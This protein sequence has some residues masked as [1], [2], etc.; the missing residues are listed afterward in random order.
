MISK[1]LLS[2]LLSLIMLVG[3]IPVSVFADEV[4]AALFDELLEEVAENPEAEEAPVETEEFEEN[5]TET[6]PALDY[7]DSRGHEIIT[8]VLP[9]STYPE[10]EHSGR[11]TGETVYEFSYP[12][13]NKLVVKFDESS[14]LGY[15]EKLTVYD[16]FDTKHRTYSY[17]D[18]NISNGSFTIYGE[19]FKLVLLS[20]YYDY[21]YGF[22]IA[23]IEVTYPE[24]VGTKAGEALPATCTEKGHKAGFIC[25]LCGED[26]PG[27]IIPA[28]GHSYAEKVVKPTADDFGYTLF[29]CTVCGD[30][31]AGSYRG[32]NSYKQG[33]I[34]ET[35]SWVI[36]GDTLYILGEGEMPNDKDR[37]D[38]SDWCG[39]VKSI[40]ITEGVTLIGRRAFETAWDA[41]SVSIPSTVTYIGDAAFSNLKKLQSADLP[42]GLTYIGQ[43]AF[44]HCDLRK[45]II[46]DSVTYLGGSAFSNNPNLAEVK[47][48][49]GITEL[50]NYAF[51]S[52]N[53]LESVYIPAKV[54]KIG[55]SAF[56]R[57]PKLWDVMFAVV[58]ES[59]EYDALRIDPYAFAYCDIKEIHL[60][61]NIGQIAGHAF[62]GNVNLKGVYVDTYDSSNGYDSTK[63]KTDDRGCVYE[64]IRNYDTGEYYQSVLAVI[65]GA[66]SGS[67]VVPDSVDRVDAAIQDMPNLNSFT[68]GAGCG[69]IAYTSSFSNCPNLHTVQTNAPQTGERYWYNGKYGEFLY[70]DDGGKTAEV[71]FLPCNATEYTLPANV[72]VNRS[73]AG[74][75]GNAPLKNVYVESGNTEFESIDGVLYKGDTLYYYP[76]AKTAKRYTVPKGIR[77]FETDAL[78]NPN[79][80]ELYFKGDFCNVE[81]D[82]L[83]LKSITV[84]YP[85]DNKTWE[86]EQL[87]EIVRSYKNAYG[88][89][90]IFKPYYTDKKP[91]APAI[92]ATVV[93]STGKPKITWNKVDGAA[94][95]EVWRATT[96]TGTGTK[97]STVTGTTLTNKNAVAGKSYYYYVKAISAGGKVSANSNR[98]YITCDYAAP[99]IKVSGVTSAGNPKIT[100]AKVEGA[101]SYKIYRATSK[102]GV[103][104][105]VKT[106]TGTSYT[107]TSGKVGKRY[108]YKV[109]AFGSNSR[110]TS[111]YSNVVSSTKLKRPIITLRSVVATGKTKVSWKAITGAE[112]YNVYRATKENGS[113]TLM[114]NVT[115]LDWIDESA[116]PGRQ[117]FYKI[118]AINESNNSGSAYSEV[119]SR[120]TDLEMPVVDIMLSSGKPKLSWKTVIGAKQ[121]KIYRA[122]SKT[123]KY[124]LVKTTTKNSWKDTTAKSGKT[125]YY[126][127]IAAHKNSNANS[128]Y[129]TVVSIKSVSN[130]KIN[131][132]SA[133]LT[134]GETLKLSIT[135]TT[136]KTTW[137]SS[138]QFVATVNSKGKVT[139]KNIGNVTIYAKVDGVTLKCEI[140]VVASQSD[141]LKMMAAMG[142]NH[143]RES[144]K[145]PSTLHIRRITYNTNKINGYGDHIYRMVIECY[146]QNSLGGY[147][148]FYT[149]VIRTEEQTD[150]RE[151]AYYSGYGEFTASSF[152]SSPGLETNVYSNSVAVDAYKAIYNTNIDIPYD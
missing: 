84:W 106:Q 92:K 24:H 66:I 4:D 15:A 130:A 53:A 149:V 83:G 16:Q 137:S 85:G 72:T 105:V 91:A 34:H 94:K 51:S 138:N 126:K 123:G 13:A 6:T 109:K 12:G 115:S 70:T 38:W 62:V 152:N 52:S 5:I 43:S 9:S 129:S 95:Y 23:S 132:G 136:K 11:E 81:Y 2:L 69:G 22:K 26:I 73:K 107:P 141:V 118:R 42:D 74:V 40:V 21:S 36:Q 117:Y 104:S 112:E 41:T 100:W 108:Y 65:P 93:T 97:L 67:Y 56:Y 28:K 77:H 134:R 127:V 20:D 33:D 139:A 8:K 44:I 48:G 87:D 54:R 122:T 140:T 99:V 35:M 133:S 128:A 144:A 31:Y 86:K 57:C 148:S 82:K 3:M 71:L 124:S 131:I 29:T 110:S 98:V 125:Y 75:F 96:K 10:S 90:V 50:P 61:H 101:T 111:A 103:Y 64:Y 89:E 120:V 47:I 88:V 143:S 80:T 78:N 37:Y 7:K 119:E 146:A 142:I 49:K 147:G 39:Q 30:S 25:E 1:R 59:D 19:Y 150:Y 121:Y 27:E 60:S 55:R 46:P 151:G 79:I 102:N 145:Y 68:F 58:P 113:Y 17:L 135:G 63:Y 14:E 32:Y 114:A 116:T 45:A 76:V 18:Y